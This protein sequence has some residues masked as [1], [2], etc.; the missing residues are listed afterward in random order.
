MRSANGCA[1]ELGSDWD[2]EV[3]YYSL[4]FL[5]LCGVVLRVVPLLIIFLASQWELLPITWAEWYA[6]FKS[7]LPFMIKVEDVLDLCND[8]Y[9]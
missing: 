9:L 5:F 1:E 2:S 6:P 7:V 3:S 8:S 4:I